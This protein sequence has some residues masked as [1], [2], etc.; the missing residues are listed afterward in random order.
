MLAKRTLALIDK[1]IAA[2]NG[3]SFRHW[4]GKYIP[5]L[6]DVYSDKEDDFRSHL[7]ASSIGRDCTREIWYGWRWYRRS[8]WNGRMLRL[9]NRGHLEEGRF[10]AMLSMIGCEVW[11]E[12]GNGEQFKVTGYKG[13]FGGSCDAVVKGIPDMP[14][15]PMLAE[16]KTHGQS[17]FSSLEGK[18][19]I[20]AKWE[21]YVQMQVY[22]A[23]LGLTHG[24][25]FAVNKN[26]DDLYAEIIELNLDVVERTSQKVISIVEAKDP[27]PRLHNATPS[28]YKCKQCSFVAIC[29]NEEAPE[30]TC[31]S[32]VWVRVSDGGEWGCAYPELTGGYDELLMLNKE[33]QRNSPHTCGYYQELGKCHKS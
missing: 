8:T 7:G 26:T 1:Q 14:N 25:Y 33:E 9:F 10:L 23:G 13:H 16:F 28:W 21:H 17:S 18:G 11:H 27:P 12:T 15:I 22:M 32:C 30:P 6:K 31:R 19:L 4:L 24:I 2:D 20:L 29:H 3:N 5:Q